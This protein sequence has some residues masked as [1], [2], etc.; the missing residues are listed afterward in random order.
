MVS[1]LPPPTPAL[2]P[3][4]I[5]RPAP[6][7]ATFG[8]VVATVSKGTAQ[9]ILLVDGK[10]KAVKVVRGRRVSVELTLPRHDVVLQLVAVGNDGSRARSRRVGPVLG[11]PAAAAP[12]DTRSV[13][14][15]VLARRVKALA[16]AFRGTAGV[17]VQDLRSGRGAAW[18]A[19]AR[20]PAASTLKLAI[21]V[22]TLR[23]LAGQPAAGS[24]VDR[25]LRSMLFQSSNEAAN[26][27][28][29]LVGGSTSG[30]SARV[31]AMMQA[32]GLVDSDMYGGYEIE[33]RP[34]PAR[35]IPI[36]TE[37]QPSI[38]RT[39]YSTAWD[40]GRLIRD[41]HFAAG[42]RGPLV[43]RVH[44]FTV[45]EARYL[46]YLLAHVGDR[47]KLGRFLPGSVTIAHKAGW[48]ATARHDNG[49]VYWP[50]GALVATVMAWSPSGVGTS[51][52]VLAGKVARA[53][54]ERFRKLG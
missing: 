24:D 13:E 19:K 26:R 49:I 20:F 21:A 29:I 27:L 15:A 12:R 53:A 31:N 52:D 17:Y 34:P 6:Y 1:H 7:Q 50:G 51:A 37:S 14:D 43:R 44:G 25:L 41:V 48:I 30:G 4:R 23:A 54:L 16:A 35:P 18:N 22:E 9:V 8:R 28:E 46:L 42:G 47:G 10:R 36:H 32:L 45:A 2:D 33:P 11:L 3:P 38:A 5:V 39:K 40:L